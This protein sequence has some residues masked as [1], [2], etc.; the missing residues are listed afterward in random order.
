VIADT[1]D[2]QRAAY[3]RRLILVRPDQHVAWTADAPPADAA[4]VLRRAVG[5]AP[6]K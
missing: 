5:V 2:G 1:A 4:A 6:T 3:G